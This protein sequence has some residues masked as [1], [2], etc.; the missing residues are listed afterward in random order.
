MITAHQQRNQREATAF[1]RFNQQSLHRFLNRQIELFNQFRD[2]FRVRRINQR[3]FLGSSSARFFRR[4]SFCQLNVRCIVRG[5]GEDHIVF[6]ALRQHLEF[7]RGATADRTGVGLYGAEIQ[8]HAAEDFAVGRIHCIVGFLQGFLRSM[9]RVSIFHQEFAG[10]HDAETRTHFVAELGLDL[11]EVQ[12]Q[13]FVRAQL[14]TNQVCNNFFM[15]WA[16]YERTLATVNKT[17]QFRTVLFPTT[18][19]LPQIGWLNHRHRHLDRTGVVHLFTHDVF[20]FFQDAHAGRQP[21]I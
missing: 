15:S 19:L 16:E 12:R 9:E 3:H 10:T 21:G 1:N 18:T 5:V 2:G 14:V 7:V 4:D 20:D 6:T 8:P 11:I 13:L 17:Q